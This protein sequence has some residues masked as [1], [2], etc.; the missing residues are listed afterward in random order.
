M[1]SIAFRSDGSVFVEGTQ[2]GLRDLASKVR[3]HDRVNYEPSRTE[4]NT[5][6]LE[7]VVTLVVIEPNGGKVKLSRQADQLVV[8]GAADLRAILA[9]N[10]DGLADK[11]EE[12][13]PDIQVDYVPGHFY[14][15]EGSMPLVVAIREAG[16]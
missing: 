1:V 16:D 9:D 5:P 10:I 14:L 15:E 13:G 7:M 11:P 6:G 4:P 12:L 8:E 3:S 2:A